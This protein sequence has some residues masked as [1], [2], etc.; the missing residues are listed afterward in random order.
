MLE[1]AKLSSQV[2]V[3]APGPDWSLFLGVIHTKDRQGVWLKS[4]S[5]AWIK[6]DIHCMSM[7]SGVIGIFNGTHN[8]GKI[9]LAPSSK[10]SKLIP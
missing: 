9:L 3:I 7:P 8:S 2:S 10:S 5:Q 1:A 4:I 6:L